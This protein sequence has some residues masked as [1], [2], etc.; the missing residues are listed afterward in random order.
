[1]LNLN[2]KIIATQIVTLNLGHFQ[3]VILISTAT[4]N[5]VYSLILGPTYS[6][7]KIAELPATVALIIVIVITL[8]QD[9]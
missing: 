8:C 7:D 1:V 6:V 3:R 9:D 2:G 4:E 5:G